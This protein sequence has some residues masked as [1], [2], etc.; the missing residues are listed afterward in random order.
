MPKRKT[1]EEFVTEVLAL[2][3]DEYTVIG[4]YELS[5]IKLDM[6]HNICGN[7]YP[8]RPNEFLKGSRCPKCQMEERKTLIMRK[9]QNKTSQ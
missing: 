8:V 2:T 5:S 4:T 7:V 9:A 1:H 3:G 6:K